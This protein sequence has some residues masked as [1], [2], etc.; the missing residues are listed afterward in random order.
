MNSMP[1]ADTEI[2]SEDASDA[3]SKVAAAVTHDVREALEEHFGFREFLSGQE[4]VVTAL[5][6]GRDTLAVMPTGGGKSLCYQLPAL[7]MNGVTLVVSPLIALMKDQ[8]DALERKGIAATLINSTLS[9]DEQQQ[10]IRTMSEGGYKLVYVAPERFRSA[11]FMRALREVPI[12]LFAVDEAHCLSQW[13]HDFR[14]DYLRLARAV[15][16]LG[17]PQ[18]AAFTATATPTVRDDIQKTL[19]LSDPF[20]SVSG[21]ERPNLSLRVAQCEKKKVKF[22]RMRAVIHSHKTGIVY[23]ATRRN[24]EEVAESIASWGVKVMA[25][26]GG[27]ADNER[28]RAQNDFING[29]YDVAVA[30]NAFGMGID[31]SDVRFVVHF[32]VPGSLEAYYQEAGRAGR[33]GEPAVCELLFNYADTRTQEF[34]IAG[35]NPGYAVICDVYKTL[36]QRANESGEVNLPIRQLADLVGA[37]NDMGVSSAISTL[38]RAGALQRYDVAGQRARGTRLLKRDTPVD[39]LGVDREAL[40]EKEQ[41]DSAKLQAMIKFSYDRGCRQQWILNYFGEP[42]PQTCGNCDS[43]L[44]ESS[45][46]GKRSLTRSAGGAPSGGGSARRRAPDDVEM[47]IAQKALSGVARASRK[48]ADGKWVGRFGKGKIVGMLVGSQS[49]EIIASRLDQL[50]T[51]GLLKDEGTAYVQ[52]LLRELEYAGL[53]ETQMGDYPLLTLSANGAKAMRG[54]QDFEL[55]WPDRS[56]V[57][58]GTTS[59]SSSVDVA[60]NAAVGLEEV[61]LDVGLLEALKEKRM[62]LASAE[63]GKPAYTIFADAT[64]EFFARLRPKTTEA[65]LRIRGV[66]PMKAERYLEDFL[67]II[68]GWESGDQQVG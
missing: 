68:R 9:P 22:E 1:S 50:S 43:C 57:A 19:A 41:R 67:E 31:R 20:V 32:E 61:A 33:D 24:V 30:T 23:C 40:A 4:Q 63:G 14:P 39:Q 17:H 56:Q 11:S 64:L 12:A 44:A 2:D 18:T 25:Y 16:E 48:D 38:V 13:G 8:V 49:K 47:M 53:L 6:S 28:E 10:R 54:D 29:S 51:H 65:G 26:H 55:R 7:V 15:E 46:G 52:T 37:K 60:M 66:G 3:D 59:S 58:R 36:Q 34:F 5:V 62:E 21:F 45:G 27:M 35:N 42:D